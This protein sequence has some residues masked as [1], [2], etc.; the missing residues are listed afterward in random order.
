M[1][2]GEKEVSR[3][4]AGEDAPGAIAS[5]RRWRQPDDQEAGAGIAPA[6]HRPP[7][8]LLVLETLD[9]HARHLAAPFPQPGTALAARHLVL[10]AGQRVSGSRDQRS[11]V[12]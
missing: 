3:A 2:S 6:R 9:L 12:K 8:I 1:K 5:M 4:I 10:H 11:S 7:P